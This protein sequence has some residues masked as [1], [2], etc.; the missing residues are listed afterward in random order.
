MSSP[1]SESRHALAHSARN[2]DLIGGRW[3]QVLT[4]DVKEGLELIV[5]TDRLLEQVIR[6]E[7]NCSE[8]DYPRCCGILCLIVFRC[9]EAPLSIF[10]PND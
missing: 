1:C 10:Y 5:H 7:I 2:V 6:E 9:S 3:E 8:L 4:R